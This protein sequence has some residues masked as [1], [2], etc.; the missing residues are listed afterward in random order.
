MKYLPKIIEYGLYLLVFLLP[1][2]TRYIIKAGEINGGYWEYGTISLYAI[3]ILLIIILILFT[4]YK[5]YRLKFSNFLPTVNPYGRSAVGM[6]DLPKGDKFLNK[7]RIAVYWWLILGLLA[8]TFISI[9][10]AP[11]KMV[12]VF[13]YLKFL[14]GIGLFW[15]MVSASYDK[16]KLI[17]SFLSGITIQAGLAIWQFISQSGFS[18]KW[19][20]MALHQATDLGASV[21]ETMGSD[22][23]GER[24]LRAYGG[25]DHPNILGGLLVIGILVAI[26]LIANG[27]SLPAVKNK[28]INLISW[29]SLLLFF[30]A[31]IFTWSR[32]AWLALFI[33]LAVLLIIGLVRKNLLRQKSI[34]E[35]I[36]VLGLILFILFNLYQNLFV[37]RTLQNERLEI[38]SYNERIMSYKNF[39]QIIK[40]N[41]LTGTGIGNYTLILHDQINKNLASFN[42]QPVHNT[43][44][45]IWAESGIM[46][47]IFFL[48]LIAYLIIKI[49]KS[50]YRSKGDNLE[51]NIILITAIMVMMMFDHWWWSL[52]FG[53]LFFWLVVGLIINK[54]ITLNSPEK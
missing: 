5:V 14:L 47:L 21:I 39:F 30:I 23:I 18:A 43:F 22:G 10:F 44:L 29:L 37:T 42:Y 27:K 38:K 49:F 4:V 52:H 24:W 28:F 2:Q 17:I 8:T 20:G 48:S 16:L 13:S 25:L 31:L 54:S 1:W 36:L 26:N 15:L 19:L 3:D 33:C 11:D 53:I 46:G 12:A 34:L 35:I 32:A 45:L 41:W 6:R 7:S 40:N 50:A 51:L 9:F